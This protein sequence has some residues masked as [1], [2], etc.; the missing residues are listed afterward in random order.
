M[1]DRQQLIEWALENGFAV[2][3]HWSNARIYSMVMGG[4][5]GKT[6]RKISLRAALPAPSDTLPG[7]QP[8]SS[9]R[10]SRSEVM[11]KAWQT[12]KSLFGPSGFKAGHSPLNR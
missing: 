6:Y 10:L 4:L 7:S 12:R 8:G 5:I 2:N 3:K 9:V 1:M 11:R